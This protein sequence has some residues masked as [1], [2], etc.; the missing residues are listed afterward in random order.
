MSFGVIFDMDGVL[1]ASGPAHAASWKA[2]ARRHNVQI[3]DQ[4][5]HGTFGRT[6]REIIQL[7]W[8]EQVNDDAARRIDDEKEAC[9]RELIRGMVPLM[10][11]ARETIQAL[12]DADIPIAIATSGPPENVELVLSESRLAPFFKTVVT[13]MDVQRGKPAPDVFLLAGERLGLKPNQCLVVEDAPVGIEAAHAAGMRVLALV[14]THPAETLNTAGADRIVTR[15]AEVT[16]TLV[17]EML[18]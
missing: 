18:A 13:G 11:G 17:R 8:G 16:P 9:Y 1:V 6:S 5:F 10:I 14:G 15:L 4:Q 3:S 2:V 12:R 7:L